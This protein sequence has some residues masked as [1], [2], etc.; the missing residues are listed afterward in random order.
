MT[1]LISLNLDAIAGRSPGA[2]GRPL[3]RRRQMVSIYGRQRLR[4]TA[5]PRSQKT[6]F[7]IQNLKPRT[8]NPEPQTP[9]PEPQTPNPEP[10][11]L[12][13]ATV[14]RCRDRAGIAGRFPGGRPLRR[15]RGMMSIYGRRRQLGDRSPRSQKSRES[16]TPNSKLQTVNSKR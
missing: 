16:Q 13:A 7:R 12:Q 14:H 5:S 6:E 9:N 15:R 3:R 1:N 8:P 10:Q 4:G 11:T 2:G